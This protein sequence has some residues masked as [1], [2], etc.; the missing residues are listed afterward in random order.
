VLRLIPLTALAEYVSCRSQRSVDS[1]QRN[2]CAIDSLGKSASHPGSRVLHCFRHLHRTMIIGKVNANNRWQQM[3]DRFW[4]RSPQCLTVRG[5]RKR[6]ART[7][8]QWPELPT[9]GNRGS[10]IGQML[11]LSVYNLVGS[12]STMVFGS[13]K[14]RIRRYD[15]W[16]S[17]LKRHDVDWYNFA[18]YLRGAIIRNSELSKTN[19]LYILLKFKRLNLRYF[20]FNIC[21]QILRL[22]MFRIILLLSK[23][24]HI[25][26]RFANIYFRLNYSNYL[27]LFYLH[28]FHFVLYLL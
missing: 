16:F 26:Q 23:C 4:H 27:D 11:N 17:N 1:C 19:E 22:Y 13:N 6:V 9:A 20:Q 25:I 28:I 8:V 14:F 7:S 12:I 21:L 5:R 18:R 3:R 2:T 15:G 24:K 10:L